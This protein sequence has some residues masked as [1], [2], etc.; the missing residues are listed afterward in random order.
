MSLENTEIELKYSAGKTSLSRFEAGVP[1]FLERIYPGMADG[2]H[3]R[4]KR[5]KKTF[6]KDALDTFYDLNGSV[7]RHRRLRGH[8]D[9]ELTLKARTSS[10]SMLERKE[11]DLLLAGGDVPT[12][13]EMLGATNLIT[14]RKD[15]LLYN[16]DLSGTIE[17]K[18]NLHLDFVRYDAFPVD[19]YT[20]LYDNVEDFRKNHSEIK[21]VSF[22]EVEVCKNSNLSVEEG[23]ELIGNL[24]KKMTNFFGLGKPLNV[25][26]F[27]TFDPRPRARTS[28]G[29]RIY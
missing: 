22:I 18:E 1:D 23:I 11:I 27:E 10:S 6:I 14:L 24:G 5:L 9:G 12:L 4:V 20:P 16:F 25:S 15:Y 28:S 17:S 7:L 21:T 8:P 3:G 29:P 19:A 13:M 2:F 26:L